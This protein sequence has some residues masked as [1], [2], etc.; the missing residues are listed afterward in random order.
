M[1]IFVHG[2][3]ERS[4]RWTRIRRCSAVLSPK[5]ISDKELQYVE[6]G[7]GKARVHV[8]RIAEL[9]KVSKS[10]VEKGLEDCKRRPLGKPSTYDDFVHATWNMGGVKL[11]VLPKGIRASEILCKQRVDLLSLQDVPRGD[12][13]PNIL[14]K[15][16]QSAL[17]DGGDAESVFAL[18]NG[19]CFRS[20]LH[21]VELGSKRDERRMVMS[22]GLVV[23]T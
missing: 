22:L 2:C 11:S 16:G 8:Q 12:H 13:G 10:A 6:G 5:D 9:M 18:W 14:K 3:A 17:I 7:M 1:G 15:V 21:C 19:P 23:F 20:C 4:E